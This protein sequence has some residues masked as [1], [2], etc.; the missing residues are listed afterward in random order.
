MCA[1]RPIEELLPILYPGVKLSYGTIQAML[2]GAEA[3]AR[4]FNSG[5]DVSGV[6]AGA[7]DEMFSQGEPVLA[8][9]DLDSGFLFA[10]ELS[11]TRSGAD[12]ARV[13]GQ[14]KA[15]GLSLSVVVKDA[16]KGRLEQ[17]AYGA[18]TREVEAQQQLKHIRAR[19]V[20]RRRGQ[21]QKI[22]WARRQCAQAIARY[23]A[24]EA[25]TD[26]VR[27]ALE[28]VD[29]ERGALR[30]A[31]E[32]RRLIENAAQAI[33][34]ID[35]HHCRKVGNYLGNRA[36]GLALAMG[37]LRPQLDALEARFST[38]SIIAACTVHCLLGELNRRRCT[39]ARR[40]E[41]SRHLLAAWA[42]LNERLGAQAELDPGAWTG[43]RN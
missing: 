8:G 6:S 42:Y 34:A 30:S 32:V 9:V 2:V 31:Q 16:A 11:E 3:K 37:A 1:I 7:L 19:D 29:L 12:W 27:Q 18:I 5:A 35:D 10:L 4:A 20:K 17:R 26:Q 43:I 41:T 39:G 25:A 24:F 36:P 28:C 14:S 40:T 13:L 21:R 38:D 22:A 15:Q 23:D 33:V